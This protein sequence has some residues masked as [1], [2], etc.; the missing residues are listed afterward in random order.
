[1]QRRYWTALAI[2]CHSSWSPLVLFGLM[3]PR[4]HDKHLEFRALSELVICA[5]LLL[6]HRHRTLLFSTFVSFS[7]S[8][9]SSSS[10]PDSVYCPDIS[11]NGRNSS[12]PRARAVPSDNALAIS[13][14]P[15]TVIR[16]SLCLLF[17][18]PLTTQDIIGCRSCCFSVR[19]L[20]AGKFRRLMLSSSLPVPDNTSSTLLGCRS[21]RNAHDA[22]LADCLFWAEEGSD[23][24]PSDC[25]RVGRD[26]DRWDLESSCLELRRSTASEL[27][28]LPIPCL[29]SC[30]S[31]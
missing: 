1:M 29:M 21:I 2:P 16:S 5:V 7:S 20:R 31:S 23:P 12:P 30:S 4:N 18:D 3:Q 17:P 28:A 11:F 27:A 24:S 22:C 13:S 8:F 6:Y 19:A 9:W 14:S 25:A 15:G 10:S 26:N